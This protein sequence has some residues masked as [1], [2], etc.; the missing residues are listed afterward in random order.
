MYKTTETPVT[1]ANG[2]PS[3]RYNVGIQ[4]HGVRATDLAPADWPGSAAWLA[5]ER[6]TILFSGKVGT[7]ASQ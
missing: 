4:N 5:F 1:I 6:S 3:A 7:G 2:R